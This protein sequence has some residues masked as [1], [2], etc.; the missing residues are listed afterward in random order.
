MQMKKLHNVA[1]CY[2][3]YFLYLKE[4]K[5]SCRCTFEKVYFTAIKEIVNKLLQSFRQ[6]IFSSSTQM[7]L[8]TFDIYV[9]VT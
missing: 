9:K 8:Q 6:I 1:N 4:V 2:F 5:G 7:S 3:I